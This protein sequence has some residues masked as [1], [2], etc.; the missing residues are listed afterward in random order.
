MA[1]SRIYYKADYFGI[2]MMMN[3][4]VRLLLNLKPYMTMECFCKKAHDKSRINR[5][6]IKG[7]LQSK[8][9]YIKI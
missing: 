4:D 8:Q 3:I 6:S 7:A 5:I 9:I 2:G 1:Y